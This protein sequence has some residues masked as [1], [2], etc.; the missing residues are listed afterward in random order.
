MSQNFTALEAVRVDT[1][2][3]LTALADRVTALAAQIGVGMTQAEVDQ[4][5]A[6]FTVIKDSLN[7]IG[8]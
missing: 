1:S 2:A 7:Q 3:A 5:I 6:E 4:L 8:V